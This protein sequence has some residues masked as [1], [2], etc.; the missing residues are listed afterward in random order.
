MPAVFQ[1][2]SSRW[3]VPDWSPREMKV[4]R[5]AARRVEVVVARRRS[6]LWMVEVG[7]GWWRSVE[8]RTVTKRGAA[9]H[10]PPPASTNLHHRLI[11]PPH[12]QLHD[13]AVVLELH[14]LLAKHLVIRHQF[15]VVP[16]HEVLQ[17]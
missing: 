13:P 15:E 2:N 7:G 17:P 9:L 14:H 6:R 10:Q 5:R 16:A 8:D 1:S 11:S 3:W 4:A 12:L